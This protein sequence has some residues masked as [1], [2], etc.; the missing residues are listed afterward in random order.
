MA[1]VNTRREAAIKRQSRKN[2][3]AERLNDRVGGW[4]SNASGLRHGTVQ[5]TSSGG[6]E[7]IKV[8]NRLQK[9]V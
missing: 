3:A 1:L 4:D 6:S 5:I 9:I 2:S 7:R 8:S